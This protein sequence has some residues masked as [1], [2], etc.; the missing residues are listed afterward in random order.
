LGDFENDI[1]IILKRILEKHR[2]RLLSGFIWLR[3][4]YNSRLLWTL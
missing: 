1:K 4:G 3:R 2:L